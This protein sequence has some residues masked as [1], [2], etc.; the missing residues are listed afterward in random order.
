VIDD[1]SPSGIYLTQW[2]NSLSDDFGMYVRHFKPG[3]DKGLSASLLG[4]EA[5]VSQ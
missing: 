3:I 1:T 2:H 5:R 4:S